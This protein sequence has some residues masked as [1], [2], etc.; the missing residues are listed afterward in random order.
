MIKKGIFLV[1]F[2]AMDAR[3]KVLEGHYFLDNK[4]VIVKSWTS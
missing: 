4:P 2:K 3:D 1:R